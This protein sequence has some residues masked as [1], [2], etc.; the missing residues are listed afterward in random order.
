[1]KWFNAWKLKPTW[2]YRRRDRLFENLHGRVLTTCKGER[3]HNC[4]FHLNLEFVAFKVWLNLFQNLGIIGMEKKHNPINCQKLVDKVENGR[5]ILFIPF[6][7]HMNYYEAWNQWNKKVPRD[8]NKNKINLVLKIDLPL[9][10]NPSLL[11]LCYQLMLN[12]K[13]S[14]KLHM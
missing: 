7:P 4:P 1:M 8:I 14:Q 13:L 12:Y 3:V 10:E 5:N 2:R 6:I 11:Q 9:V